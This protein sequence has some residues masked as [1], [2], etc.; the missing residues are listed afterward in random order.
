MAQRMAGAQLNDF[1]SS[2]AGEAI[3]DGL[4]DAGLVTLPVVLSEDDPPAQEA[5][6]VAGAAVGGVSA[7]L[8][9][10]SIDS[11]IQARLLQGEL[12]RPPTPPPTSFRQQMLAPQHPNRFGARIISG[13]LSGAGAAGGIWAANQLAHQLQWD[14]HD[15]RTSPP[16]TTL[17]VQP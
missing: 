15:Q 3:T 17:P 4:L 14:A 9:A 5:L 11:L 6:Q 7:G 10:H 12:H 13:L 1:L 2:R 16:P 8:A